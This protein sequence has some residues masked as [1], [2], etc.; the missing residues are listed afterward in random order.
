[1]QHATHR[2]PLAITLGMAIALITPSARADCFDD[3]AYQQVTASQK[4]IAKRI[5]R[6]ARRSAG[7][8]RSGR[9]L[10]ESFIAESHSSRYMGQDAA[11]APNCRAIQ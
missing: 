10:S 9:E 3:A 7:Y 4:I 5:V 8:P 1:M 11:A 6:V 2:S